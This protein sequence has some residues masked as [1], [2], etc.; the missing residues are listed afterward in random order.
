MLKITKVE[1]LLD[2]S[3]PPPN[4]LCFN[5]NWQ[6]GQ[7]FYPSQVIKIMTSLSDSLQLTDLYS[8][9]AEDSPF[10]SHLKE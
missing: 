6:M 2:T 8:V 5:L 10:K 9:T 4:I 1:E 3:Q 7:N